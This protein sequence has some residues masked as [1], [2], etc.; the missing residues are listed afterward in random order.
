MIS[1][2]DSFNERAVAVRAGETIEV[3]LAEN[4]STGYRWI[5]SSDRGSRLDDALREVGQTAQAEGTRPGMPGVRC[6]RFE[7]LAA[8]YAELQLEY[9]RT[10]EMAA[11]P[12][13]TFR[14]RVEVRAVDGS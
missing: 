2:D 4:A 7:A 9:R 10:W 5:V 3:T 6:F 14:L 11:E 12:A 1:I 8:G 13:R